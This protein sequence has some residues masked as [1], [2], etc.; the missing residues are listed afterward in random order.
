MVF[1]KDLKPLTA[2]GTVTKHRG[3]GATEQR[4][5]GGMQESVT[6]P[7]SV[8]RAMGSYPKSAPPASAPVAPAPMTPMGPMPPDEG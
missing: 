1:K 2:R 7:P 8:G 6:G 5:T 3:K 4:L